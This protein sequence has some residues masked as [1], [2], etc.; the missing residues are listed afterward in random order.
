MRKFGEYDFKKMS[1]SR[2]MYM[3]K[4]S[5]FL[6]IFLVIVII[7]LIGLCI[8]SNVA[9]KAE[10]VE[11]SGIVVAIDKTPLVIETNGKISV[12]NVNEG[13]QAEEGDILFSFDKSQVYTEMAKY[14]YLRDYYEERIQFIDLFIQ[15]LENERDMEGDYVPT[16]PFYSEGRELEFYNLFETYLTNLNAGSSDATTLIKSQESSLLS[17]KN[18][19]SSELESY[20]NS[21]EQYNL[22]LDKY[23][24]LAPIS[25]TVHYDYKLLVGTVLSSGT[26]IGSMSSEHGEKKLEMYVDASARSKINEGDEC[27]FVLN[28][29]AQ[30]EFGS[31]P[32]VVE[33]ISSDATISDNA[34]YF[35][36]IVT[37]EEDHMSNRRGSDVDIVNGMQANVWITVEKMT[38]WNYFMEQLGLYE[39]G[40]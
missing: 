21:I 37:F 17:E 12:I 19:C 20:E 5:K 10:T 28:G 27:Y 9:V 26:E 31:V 23:D 3:Q 14:E 8:W 39:L 13:G 2:I 6:T 30:T 7:I 33:S 22:A 36:T 1:D 35:K 38:Y 18:S 32:G 40:I 29:L 24:I 15:E 11:T 25:G 16:N 34:I 4:P